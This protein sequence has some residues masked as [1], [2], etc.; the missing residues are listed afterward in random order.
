MKVL[1][2]IPA[3]NEE[4]SLKWVIEEIREVMDKT[5]YDYDILVIDDGSND[6][7]AEIAKEANAKVNSHPQNLG[8]A[9][10]FRTEMRLFL[11]TD[12]EV[13]VHTDADGQYFARDIPNLIKKIEEGC[14]LVLGSRFLGKITGMPLGNKI[15]NK[16]FAKVF[17]KMIGKKLTD[18][19]TGF[20]AF[21]RKVASLKIINNFTYTQE[22]IIKAVKAGFK[23]CEVGI[24]TRKTRPS[25]LFK[26]PFDYALKAWINILRIYRDFDPLKFFGRL[27]MLFF[28]AGFLIGLWLFYLFLRYDRIGHIPLTILSVLLMLIG[29]Q[30]I[31]FGF[32]ADMKNSKY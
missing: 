11:E 21:T 8:L 14:D 24:D 28:S 2:S 29:I 4:K 32:L 13:I 5:K 6:K 15:G 16:I 30:I 1:I 31:L 27:G 26:N 20:R 9:D 17:S 10:T 25:R 22:Q 12:Y 19:T 3:Y 18:T 23:V 7:T